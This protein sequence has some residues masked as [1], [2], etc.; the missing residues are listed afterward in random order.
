MS[1][2]TRHAM[3]VDP[4]H[5]ELAR[6]SYISQLR[7]HV[8]NDIGHGMK[9]VYEQRVKPGFVAA[10]GRPPKDEHEV[11]RA[12]LPDPYFRSWSTLMR[13]TQ[14]MI[15]DAVLPQVER[16]LPSLVEKAKGYADS[17]GRR[18]G[19]LQLNPDLRVP[20]Y[21]TAVDIHLQPGGYHTEHCADDVAAGAI[22]DRGV[23]VYTAGFAG[24][25]NDN[26]S[27]SLVK[28]L[29]MKYPDFEPK[30]ILDLGCSIG[31]NTVPLAQ[32][33]P[34]A[35]V[36]A[37]DV[38]APMLRYGHARAEALGVPV[39]FHQMNAEQLDFPDESFDLV[40]SVILFHETSASAIHRIFREAHRVLKPGGVMLNVELPPNA[41]MDPYDAFY[42]DW[43]AYWNNEPFY[44]S[45]SDYDT[46]ELLAKA[47]FR[48]ENYRQFLI[49]DA[50][51]SSQ[52]E[53][54]QAVASGDV[55]KTE[56]GR[57][58]ESVRWFTYG[59]VK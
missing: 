47:G 25:Q 37:V 53:F 4:T 41:D 15:W 2:Q 49:P 46:K 43:D 5:D 11:R 48:R 52:A 8:L 13:S 19:S 59:A 28:F 6:Q 10:Q 36:H 33:Y 56:T 40:Y 32:A 1:G 9:T 45:Y 16:E 30:K 3:L 21:N 44:A 50:Y 22:F 58:G 18:K 55:Q 57:W 26:L 23:Y 20:K 12:M 54:E 42:I 39:H 7:M 17:N 24:P 29:K 31:G 51:F 35:E 14:E 27:Q 34:E 38:A